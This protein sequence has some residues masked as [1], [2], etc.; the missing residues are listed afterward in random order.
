MEYAP[1]NR[2]YQSPYK[3]VRLIAPEEVVVHVGRVARVVLGAAF[4]VLVVATV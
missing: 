4:V 3:Y 1:E 2:G